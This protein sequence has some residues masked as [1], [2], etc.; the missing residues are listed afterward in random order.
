[1]WQDYVWE[2]FDNVLNDTRN[3]E[4]NATMVDMESHSRTVGHPATDVPSFF[5]AELLKYMYLTFAPPKVVSLDEWVFNTRCH[6]F[7]LK[8]YY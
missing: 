8:G 4:P 2:P 1:M 6:P 3:R 5:F 7:K